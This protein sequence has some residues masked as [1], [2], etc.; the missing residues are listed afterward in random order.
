MARRHS[1]GGAASEADAAIHT[2]KIVAPAAF[3]MIDFAAA[4]FHDARID[5]GAALRAKTHRRIR[6][7]MIEIVTV[8]LHHVKLL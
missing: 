2:K 3:V 1:R 6:T 7:A 8:V 5:D 4:L